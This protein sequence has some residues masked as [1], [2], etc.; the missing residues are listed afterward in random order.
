M[1][2]VVFANSSRTNIEIEHRYFLYFILISFVQLQIDEKRAARNQQHRKTATL[3]VFCR[4]RIGIANENE[5]Q[6][7]CARF[8]YISICRI[9]CI[10]FVV[11][12]S[13][14]KPAL[15]RLLCGW[16]TFDLIAVAVP[17]VSES[18]LDLETIAFCFISSLRSTRGTRIEVL[19]CFNFIDRMWVK[20]DLNKNRRRN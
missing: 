18:E 3:I 4:R 2:A 9:F 5:W 7:E 14:T 12:C 8:F 1:N 13:Q 17:S 6:I 16:S 20:W 15:K 19:F 11:R 10:S